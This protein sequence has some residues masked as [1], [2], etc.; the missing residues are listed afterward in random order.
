MTSPAPTTTPPPAPNSSTDEGE[1]E[2]LSAIQD[3]FLDFIQTRQS[4]LIPVLVTLG[5]ALVLHIVVRWI[6][7]RQSSRMNREGFQW[8]GVIAS[9]LSAPAGLVI[10]VLALTMVARML[11][12]P[13]PTKPEFAILTSRIA[14]VRLGLVLA[15]L[16][17]FF[18]RTIRRLEHKFAQ[19]AESSERLDLTA[20]HAIAN[21]LVVLTWIM[22]V[23]IAAQSYG[24]NMAAILTLGGASAFALSFAFQDVFKNLFGGIMILFTRPFRVGDAVT[25][26]GKNLSG[27]IERIG[28]YQT[29]MRGWDKIPV[30]IPNSLFLTD[31]VK[32]LTGITQRRI[33]FIIGLR[34]QD[35]D[36]VKPVVNEIETSLKNHEDVDEDALLRVVFNNFGDSSLDITI[37]CNSQPGASAGDAAAMQ[38]ELMIKVGEIVSK[39][40]ADFPFPTQTLD[41]TGPIEIK[42]A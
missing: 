1:G 6:L 3:W 19:Q 5:I 16:G 21:F 42:N 34:Y 22:T 13:D 40:G 15:L 20:V 11:I 37:T 32:N 31:P 36:Q 4:V 9:S 24:M 25:M 29:R 8:T 14:Q 30:I 28:L 12:A 35:F 27:S 2:K 26:V 41:L 23:L 18:V 17:W 7:R 38:E 39:H 33:E 10:W